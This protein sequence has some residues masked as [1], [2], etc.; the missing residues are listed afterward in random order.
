M[1]D[2]V[3]YDMLTLGDADCI[4]VSAWN[5]QT[6]SRVLIDGG[7]KNDAD[8]V[9]SFLRGMNISHLDAV[10]STHGHDDHSGGLIELLADETLDIALLLSHVPQW[11]VSSMDGVT[12]ALREAGPSPEADAIRKS[13]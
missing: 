11:H 9:R 6:V 5:G 13:L 4:L 2:G 3:E 7:Y 1:Y 10:L 8:K 12:K